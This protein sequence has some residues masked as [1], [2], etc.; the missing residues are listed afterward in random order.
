MK[1]NYLFSSYPIGDNIIPDEL[2]VKNISL[3]PYGAKYKQKHT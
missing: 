3:I 2:S 1:T